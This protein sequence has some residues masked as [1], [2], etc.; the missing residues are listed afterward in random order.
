MG[1]KYSTVTVTGYN[2][3]PPADDGSQVA[4]NQVTWAK[5]KTKLGDPLKTAIEAVDAKLV[6]ALDASVR[7]ATT[8]DSTVAGDNLKTIQ[9]TTNTAGFTLSLGDATTMAAGYIVTVAN[10]TTSLGN[11]TVAVTTASDHINNVTNGTKTIFPGDV[12]TFIVASPARGYLIRSTSRQLTLATP[13]ATTSGTSIDFTGIPPGTKRITIMF[14]GVST[15]GTSNPLIQIGDSGGIETS[16]YL[17][18]GTT[19]VSAGAIAIANFTTG[20]GFGLALAANVIHGLVI[21]VLQNALTNT[22]VATGLLGLSNA[23]A[24]SR[25]AGSKPL[26]TVLD[27]VRITTANGADTFDAGEINILYE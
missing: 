15:N 21:L 6:T 2:A 27:R 14:V 5:S 3:S 10:S 19:Q 26:S 20:F 23:A 8:T 9:C 25:T 7:T 1:T 24:E 12:M 4:S 17:G 16:G 11:V 22:W 13:Q 18:M